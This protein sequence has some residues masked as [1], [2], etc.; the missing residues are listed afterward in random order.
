[1]SKF[2]AGL[3]HIKNLSLYSIH[4]QVPK[5]QMIVFSHRQLETI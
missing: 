1:M 3:Q 4:S 2:E 5:F